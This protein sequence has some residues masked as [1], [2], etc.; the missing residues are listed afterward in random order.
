MA[1]PK[2]L[3]SESLIFVTHVLFLFDLLLKDN[4]SL[5]LNSC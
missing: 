5:F 1:I 4:E 2:I 3:K